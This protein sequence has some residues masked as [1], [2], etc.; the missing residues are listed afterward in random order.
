MRSS[1]SSAWVAVS[2]GLLGLVGLGGCGPLDEGLRVA[3]YRLQMSSGAYADGSGRRG[4]ALLATFRDAQGRGPAEPWTATLSDERGPL[5]QP[6]SYDSAALGSYGAWWW[7]DIGLGG[8]E[9]YTLTLTRAD[10]VRLSGALRASFSDG[11][12][13]PRVDLSADGARLLWDVVDGAQSYACRVYS[14]GQLQLSTYV[15]EPGC[16]VSALPPGSY[17]A[18]VLALGA[19]LPALSLDTSQAPVLPAEF[20]VSEGRMAFA[21]GGGAGVL[22]AGVAGGSIDYG[23]STSG[24]AVWL[25]LT[26]V[27]GTPL[28]EPWT[29][30]ILGPGLPAQAPLQLTYPASARQYLFWSYETPAL[31]GRYT[32][33]ATSSAGSL[34]TTFS[35]GYSESLPVV[36]DAVAAAQPSGGARVTWTA[37]AGART[38]YVSAWPEGAASLA[39][40]LWVTTPDAH[41]PSGTFTT[42]QRYDVYV[43]ATNVDLTSLVAPTRVLVSE[44]TYL[45]ASFVAE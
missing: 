44:N 27:D 23:S 36:T 40:S 19:N 10:G 28:A 45:P 30:E 37:V 24:L 31:E 38:Y 17:S 26:G 22:R 21:A 6:F 32:L 12:D 11:L 4:Q 1:V 5:G 13:P 41:F 35:I 42:G 15:L 8:G 3:G 2:C 33:A 43:A 18:S 20:H 29:V 34:S 14:D 16:D 39:S 7:P 25:S 9:P